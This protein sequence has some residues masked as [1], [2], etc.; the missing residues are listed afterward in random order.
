[1]LRVNA[2]KCKFCPDSGWLA[3]LALK[4]RCVRQ[5]SERSAGPLCFWRHLLVL[6]SRIA[7][8]ASQM[9]IA[10]SASPMDMHN[11]P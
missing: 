9:D 8:S 3:A 7:L 10:L 6:R 5:S 4:S 11:I 1:M 2:R